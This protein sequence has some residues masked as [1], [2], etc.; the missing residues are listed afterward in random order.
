MDR[1]SHR[2]ASHRNTTQKNTAQNNTAQN[3][4]ATST[5]MVGAAD[6]QSSNTA[7]PR[8]SLP[9][10]NRMADAP[11]QQRLHPANDA[12]NTSHA[13]HQHLHQ[14]LQTEADALVTSTRQ[15]R[16]N[17]VKQTEQ[18]SAH[19]TQHI[20]DR[21]KALNK[22]QQHLLTLANYARPKPNHDTAH[23][24]S[25]ATKLN[26]IA[27]LNA[28]Q[29]E[30]QV[31]SLYI[32]AKDLADRL[33][34]EV[35][36]VNTGASQND[37]GGHDYDPKHYKTL[38]LKWAEVNGNAWY[39]TP[40]MSV[41]GDNNA[42]T[43]TLRRLVSRIQNTVA[44]KEIQRYSQQTRHDRNAHRQ[45]IIAAI[46]SRNLAAQLIV[47][48][49]K[50][51]ARTK[52]IL[53]NML[54]QSLDHIAEEVKTEA[55]AELEQ[56][57]TEIAQ[58]KL[59]QEIETI[60]TKVAQSHRQGNHSPVQLETLSQLEHKHTLLEMPSSA[61]A[62]IDA[63]YY[64]KL[65]N[66][67]ITQLNELRQTVATAT[68]PDILD[69]VSA[70]ACELD[71]IKD[72]TKTPNISETLT[73]H[74]A[75]LEQHS[76][77][78]ETLLATLPKGASLY[79]KTYNTLE[80]V[81]A[82]TVWI[83][84]FLSINQFSQCVFENRIASDEL[85]SQ[86]HRLQKVFS[87]AFDEESLVLE[88]TTIPVENLAELFKQRFESASRELCKRHQDTTL[89]A[90]NNKR[91]A[92]YEKQQPWID[93]IGN[94]RMDLILLEYDFNKILNIDCL[95]H[96]IKTSLRFQLKELKLENDHIA[97]LH[98]VASLKKNTL[99]NNSVITF[100]TLTHCRS[101][102]RYYRSSVSATR[103]RLNASD[104]S[105]D[106]Y[107]RLNQVL[108]RCEYRM[109]SYDHWIY[110]EAAKRTVQAASQTRGNIQAD[111]TQ[112]L[113]H[114]GRMQYI[115]KLNEHIAQLHVQLQLSN[116]LTEDINQLLLTELQMCTLQQ[117]SFRL[118]IYMEITVCIND[119][120][121]TFS[122][123][124]L[125]QSE[126]NRLKDFLNTEL[127]QQWAHTNNREK[128]G[129][130]LSNLMIALNALQN[131]MKC[132]EQISHLDTAQKQILAQWPARL[133]Q[134][135]PALRAEKQDLIL[136]IAL[137][138][139]TSLMAMR[140]GSEALAMDLYSTV[141]DAACTDW[142]SKVLI[143]MQAIIISHKLIAALNTHLKNS[144]QDPEQA[145]LQKLETFVDANRKDFQALLNFSAFQSA[146]NSKEIIDPSNAES[147]EAYLLFYI[148]AKAYFT[149]PGEI[150]LDHMAYRHYTINNVLGGANSANDKYGAIHSIIEGAQG[151]LKAHYLDQLSGFFNI[152]IWDKII[153]ALPGQATRDAQLKTRH[154][155]LM[156]EMEELMGRLSTDEIDKAHY[157]EEL[158]ALNDRYRALRN[159]T[160]EIP[161]QYIERLL[162]RI[163]GDG[164]KPDKSSTANA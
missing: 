23:V 83:R 37:N 4:G 79:E 61:N 155:E 107:E 47:D 85:I 130:F 94:Y 151:D 150:S 70:L 149:L 118:E 146:T 96:D 109:D 62:S 116:K 120:D 111:Q 36:P 52:I 114:N 88:H 97:L 154:D 145:R 7:S 41:Y 76:Q 140:D 162:S 45:H 99:T 132:I 30:T 147:V 91:K 133:I 137:I 102:L 3:N 119:I 60:Q 54:D 122:K 123:T 25:E 31:L 101:S 44:P 67:F 33:C 43:K 112:G 34:R 39:P 74:N 128:I 12:Q 113:T 68:A 24:I 78:L 6:G 75:A 16:E 1:L 14:H 161:A 55:K 73:L 129:Q 87:S 81:K 8:I 29:Q 144:A 103:S 65:K 56:L 46:D 117:Q 108:D 164:K 11:T 135:E 143:D 42:V 84:H 20:D 158:D 95:S 110:S 48:R 5:P 69:K 90:L 156:D 126:Q 28:T 77:T 26:L 148:A 124:S 2:N 21:L 9:S 125:S 66:T 152:H 153:T 35:G 115:R 159:T 100:Q 57:D 106:M 50:R 93:L 142:A 10:P 40:A 17:F 139:S 136:N 80:S 51:A 141:K 63:Q 72:L 15:S 105:D 49:Y 86:C 121:T 163:S 71:T 157:E 53:M 104:I 13:Q 138:T 38:T 19:N 98:S 160:H 59:S 32:Q 64:K 89:S 127:Q 18:S 58:L 131:Q 134:H 22:T 27:E 92:F 82:D